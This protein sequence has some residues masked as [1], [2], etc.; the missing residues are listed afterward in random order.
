VTSNHWTEH[1]TLLAEAYARSAGWLRF[2]LVTRALSMHLPQSPQRVV[3]V[4]GGFGRQAIML[5]RSGHS[6]VIVDCDPNMLSIARRE[7]ATETQEVASRIELLLGDGES[8][9]RVA[10]SGFDLACCHSVLMYQR[11]PMPMLASLVELVR[12]GGLISILCVNKAAIAMRSG[13]QRR[14]R[15]AAQSLET[16]EE[17][18]QDYLPTREHS[19]DEVARMLE[20]AGARITQWY[21]VGIFTDHFTEKI[22]PEELEEVCTAEWLAGSRDPY[23]QVARCFHII[24][25]RL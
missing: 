21:G 16:G 15:E 23:R 9:A 4:G 8:A 20:A 19:R 5:A 22:S 14:W 17:A 11:D 18:G 12:R 7:I 6:V 3:D 1:A 24:A 10:G 13:L 25:E 2:E